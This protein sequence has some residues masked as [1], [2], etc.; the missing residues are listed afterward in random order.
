MVLAAVLL[1][2]VGASALFMG[3]VGYPWLRLRQF[4]EPEK[5][6][7]TNGELES[8]PNISV[9]LPV[10]NGANQLRERICNLIDTEYPARKL[11]I[12]I[13]CDGCT[14]ATAE[15]AKEVAAEDVSSA[16]VEVM[17][18]PRAGKPATLNA[19]AER[20]TGEWI[21]IVDLGGLYERDTLSHLIMAGHSSAEV[22]LVTGRWVD[23]A[24]D[25]ATASFSAIEASRASIQERMRWVDA[26][27]A[28]V[29]ITPWG[30]CYAVRRATFGPIPKQFLLEDGYLGLRAV[31][32]HHTAAV[33]W[34]ATFRWQFALDQS[35][36]LARRRRLAAGSYQLLWRFG[37]LLLAVNQ[38]R[39]QVLWGQKALLWLVPLWSLFL[40][41]GGGLLLLAVPKFALPMAMFCVSFAVI[42]SLI[43]DSFSKRLLYGIQA[44]AAQ[45]LGLW[46]AVRGIDRAIWK[47]TK[48]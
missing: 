36:Q 24:G 11:Q 6:A 9:L 17:D 40:A 43:S 38:R 37:S 4:V 16:R 30:P 34:H 12:L 10:H 22:T 32:Q 41:C 27:N 42:G 48:R 7:L 1:L 39:S 25:A 21:V 5:L 45:L 19:L 46:D 20:A 44:A 18:L 33:A 14:D 15:L 31:E 47:P 23:S 29:V 35:T 3:F 26:Q 8:L 28:G 2:G 13:G